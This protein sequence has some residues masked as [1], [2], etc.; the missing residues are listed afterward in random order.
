MAVIYPSPED[1]AAVFEA[2]S[3]LA[4]RPKDVQTTSDGPVPLG[5]VVPDDVYERWV[6]QQEKPAA[7]AK[8]TVPKKATPAKKESTQ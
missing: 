3:S 6:A 7:P 4:A 8:Q 1:F 5:L 2:V